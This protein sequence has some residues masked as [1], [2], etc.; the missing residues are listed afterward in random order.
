[1]ANASIFDILTGIFAGSV[2]LLLVAALLTVYCKMGQTEFIIIAA[3]SGVVA[4]SGAVFAAIVAG[5][6]RFILWAR[7]GSEEGKIM[8][9]NLQADEAKLLN[10]M[11]TELEFQ[12]RQLNELKEL[13]ELKELQKLLQLQGQNITSIRDDH[14]EKGMSEIS[15]V[16]Q[17]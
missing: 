17:L 4:L 14:M 1:M 9:Q 10:A 8:V 13:H 15:E 3:V 5:R 7:Y 11:R 6:N 16:F 12:T 2:L